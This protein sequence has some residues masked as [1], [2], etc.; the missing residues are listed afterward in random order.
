MLKR[1]G[2]FLRR[3]F[4]HTSHP[5]HS[6]L[7]G[8]Q[9]SFYTPVTVAGL[10]LRRGSWNM[11]LK[12]LVDYNKMDQQKY[13]LCEE[14]Y[15]KQTD[16]SKEHVGIDSHLLHSGY[17]PS[18]MEVSRTLKLLEE[19]REFD[20]HNNLQISLGLRLEKS[21][22]EKVLLN[23]HVARLRSI[24][25]VLHRVPAELWEIIFEIIACSSGNESSLTIR[26][27][28]RHRIAIPSLIL[29]HVCSRWRTVATGCPELWS[30]IDIELYRFGSGVEKLVR[31]FLDNSAT[32]PLD[33]QIRV[34][35]AC[36]TKYTRDTWELIT[37]HLSRSERLL[38]IFQ[39]RAVDS[40]S[41]FRGQ[42]I[43][44]NNLLSFHSKVL[45]QDDVQLDVNNPLW[46]ALS[47]APKLVKVRVHRLR[48]RI[49]LPY[50]QL[51][52]LT[53]DF[54]YTNDVGELLRVLGISKNLLSLTLK[55][56]EVTAEWRPLATVA[57][58]VELPFLHFL[59]INLEVD[60][61]MHY[62]LN[63][64]DPVLELLFASLVMPSLSILK[65]PCR[66]SRPDQMYW[67]SSLLSML[68]HSSTSLRDIS[69]F[70]EPFYS[71]QAH[72]SWESLSVLLNI[73]PHLTDFHLHDKGPRDFDR[74]ATLANG[75]FLSELSLPEF[76]YTPHN[77]PVLPE[78]RTLSIHGILLSF[79]VVNQ[80]LRL[81]ASRSPSR[82]TTVD[83]VRPLKNLYA[84]SY[85]SQCSTKFT[86]NP[87]MLEAIENLKYEGVNVVFE[88]RE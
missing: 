70:F 36:G 83:D 18:E 88:E 50:P 8:C 71:G 80:V 42:D 76:T 4:S 46:M 66:S 37:S 77:S 17:V 57:C 59:S 27:G 19:T 43:T 74:S 78:L 6:G 79:E 86:V 16:A 41:A 38:L 68:R 26:T 52:T 55:N 75:S 47:Q 84:A 61:L 60:F 33:L 48:P 1:K 31:T 7:A 9:Q 73:V 67:P 28:W 65:L 13:L 62:L 21:E 81:A 3:G 14:C 29:S 53:L 35:P 40:L 25:S 15:G 32:Y 63:V 39:D 64:N 11:D 10:D 45:L 44:L 5:A 24:V 22:N 30:S 2:H 58:R 49:S 12:P 85:R 87:Q 20:G 51:T 72:H 69:L 82:L 23:T 34:E 54:I 56:I